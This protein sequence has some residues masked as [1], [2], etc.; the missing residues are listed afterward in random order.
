MCVYVCVCSATK[1]LLRRQCYDLLC[2]WLFKAIFPE[3]DHKSSLLLSHILSTHTP[4]AP[5]QDTS[6]VNTPQE[7]FSRNPFTQEIAVMSVD[8]RVT[9]YMPQ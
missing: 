7:A 4:S 6:V 1:F 8:V 5:L 9:W 2:I 3:H